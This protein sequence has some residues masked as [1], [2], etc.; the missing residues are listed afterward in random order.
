MWGLRSR[1]SCPHDL[2][3]DRLVNIPQPCGLQNQRPDNHP[4]RTCIDWMLVT[5]LGSELASAN[6]GTKPHLN[7]RAFP[8]TFGLPGVQVKPLFS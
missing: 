8:N 3:T 1:R 7:T 2:G 6:H 5:S 4:V